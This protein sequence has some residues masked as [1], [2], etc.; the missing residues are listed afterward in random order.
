MVHL[1]LAA[2][3]RL[4]ERMVVAAIGAL[5]AGCT[6]S[7]SPKTETPDAA[8]SAAARPSAPSAAVASA[9][10]ADTTPQQLSAAR[11]EPVP[12]TPAPREL[13]RGCFEPRSVMRSVGT[14]QPDQPPPP[15]AYDK[16]GCLP[17]QQVSNGCCNAA[18]SGPRF[19]D[20]ACCYGFPTNAPCCGRPFTVDGQPQLAGV[21]AGRGWH[22][23]IASDH[24]ATD[25]ATDDATRRALTDGW[26]RDAR[27]EHASV[28]SFA[29]FVMD[30]VALGAPADLVRDAGTALLDEIEHATLCFSLASR[31]AGETLS[32]APFPAAAAAATRSFQDIVRSA[33]VEG[34]IGETAAA[35]VA[36]LRLDA[37]RDPQAQRALERIAHDEAR[38]AELAFRFVAWVLN[39]RRAEAAPVIAEVLASTRAESSACAMETDDGCE[40]AT[41]EAMGLISARDER[42]AT[43]LAFETIAQPALDLACG[44]AEGRAGSGRDPGESVSRQ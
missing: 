32:P 44:M 22:A 28:A 12:P 16:N 11:V 26:L 29:R 24:A 8:S 41:L 37:A 39:E 7:A 19:Q 17:K 38:H 21:V 36:L 13:P 34:C 15:S 40:Q 33:V 42:R 5:A 9:V 20:G 1:D 43:K 27:M 4:R 6:E 10:A 3:K 31:F 35:Y 23:A 14:G 2:A 25:A 30:L 18:V